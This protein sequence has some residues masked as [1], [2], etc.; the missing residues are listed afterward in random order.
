MPKVYNG[1]W[2]VKRRDAL[3]G[4]EVVATR[5]TF[6]SARDESRRLNSEHGTEDKF[7]VVPAD[8]KD[9]LR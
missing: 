6:T 9:E 1:P 8:T 2:S 5:E 3:I 7:F 4:N